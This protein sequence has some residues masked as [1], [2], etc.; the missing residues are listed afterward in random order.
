MTPT[1]PRAGGPSSIFGK[2]GG[3]ASSLIDEQ[4]WRPKRFAQHPAAS[5]IRT[6]LTR[7]NYPERSAG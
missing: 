1:Y 4:Y 7:R 2:P 3:A 6:Q 5:R